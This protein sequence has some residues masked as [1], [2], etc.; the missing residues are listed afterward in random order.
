ML[1]VHNEFQ[2]IVNNVGQPNRKQQ[3]NGEV[4]LHLYLRTI[5]TKGK[6]MEAKKQVTV[7]Q[8]IEIL[9]IAIGPNAE[10]LTPTTDLIAYLNCD[11]TTAIELIMELETEFEVCTGSKGMN[12]INKNH[13]TPKTL[14]NLVNNS[15]QLIISRY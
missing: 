4:T 8:V 9:I 10:G 13:V 1:A 3:A 14:T 15:Q 2:T 11:K 12:L 6:R 7:E 5:K